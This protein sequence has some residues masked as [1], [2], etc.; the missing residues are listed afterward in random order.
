MDAVSLEELVRDVLLN[1]E[2]HVRGALGLILPD[3]EEEGMAELR[4]RGYVGPGGTLTVK[5]A[6]VASALQIEE[7]GD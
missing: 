3:K 2:R 6:R 7:W 5:G 1:S 4:R